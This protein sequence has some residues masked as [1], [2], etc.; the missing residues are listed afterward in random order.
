MVTPPGS[1]LVIVPGLPPRATPI[2]P[3]EPP[4]AAIFEPSVR[5]KVRDTSA[6]RTCRLTCIGV[7]ER[8]RV[9]TLA[10]LPMKAC[11]SRV[12]SAASSG[13]ATAPVSSTVLVPRMVAVIRASGM[14]SASMLPTPSILAPTR[15]LADQSVCPAALLA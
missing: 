12:A 11:T 6:M 15:T 7:A 3:L 5:I 4:F 2:S 8:S 14:A 13:L 9:M 10:S 1:G